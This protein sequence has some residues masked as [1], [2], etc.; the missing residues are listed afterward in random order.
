MKRDVQVLHALAPNA[1]VKN[2]ADAKEADAALGVAR[3]LLRLWGENGR[4]ES[5]YAQY[6]YEHHLA[7][8]MP[9]LVAA[10]GR[11]AL[12]LAVELLDRAE[13]I[14]GRNSYSHLSMQPIAHSNRPPHDICDALLT[15]VRESAEGLVKSRTVPLRDAVKMLTSVNGQI[16]VRLSLHLLAQDP[17][18]APEEATGCLLDTGLVTATWCNAEYAALARAWYPSIT[19]E[20]QDEILRIVDAVPDEYLGWWKERFEKQHGVTATPEDEQSFRVHCVAELL[21]RWRTVLPADRQE[22]LE[23]AGDPDA[24]RWRAM[25]PDESPLASTDFVKKTAEEVVAFLRG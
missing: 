21:W 8:L 22:A 3:E 18:S 2:L 17:A 14:A 5:H 7:I 10:C 12:Q 19:P 25:A 23:K 9:A 16:F 24:W 13:S 1:L 6:M 11:D 20:N 15:A 4:I